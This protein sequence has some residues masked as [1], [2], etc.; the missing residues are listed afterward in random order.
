MGLCISRNND[1]LFLQIK[2]WLPEYI[3]Y[4]G[5]LDVKNYGPYG[6]FLGGFIEFIVII[7]K[8]DLDPKLRMNLE[9]MDSMVLNVLETNYPRSILVKGGNKIESRYMTGIRLKQMP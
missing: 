5:D 4:Y 8:Y 6:L 3:A 7:K 1:N 2:Q 9:L